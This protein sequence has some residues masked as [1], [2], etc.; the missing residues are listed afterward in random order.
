MLREFL[1][2]VLVVEWDTPLNYGRSTLSTLR[3]ATIVVIRPAACTLRCIFKT[4]LPARD[5]SHAGRSFL[6]NL[7]ANFARSLEA[8]CFSEPHGG[9]LCCRGR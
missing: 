8:K 5:I 7:A 1:F 6:A 4:V 9:S 2:E 3:A